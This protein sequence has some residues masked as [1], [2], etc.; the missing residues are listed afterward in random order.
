MQRNA[1]FGIAIQRG[2]LDATEL[3][4]SEADVVLLII[5]RTGELPSDSDEKLARSAGPLNSSCSQPPPGTRSRSAESSGLLRFKASTRVTVS[6][7]LESMI[8]ATDGNPPPW[9]HP[10]KAHFHTAG[11]CAPT[12]PSRYATSRPEASTVKA[13]SG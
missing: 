6:C 2:C 3:A 5:V 1:G 13:V 9:H 7:L 4:L 11:V 12:M 10:A 8:S